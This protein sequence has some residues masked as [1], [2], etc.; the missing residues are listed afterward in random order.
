MMEVCHL[1]GS[2]NISYPK[3]K[4]KGRC[5]DCN[6]RT[7]AKYRAKHRQRAVDSARRSERKN[8]YGITDRQVEVMIG[9]QDGKCLVCN[10]P[11]TKFHID[12]CH[13]SGAVRGILCPGCNVGLGHFKER[14][15]AL[16]GAIR[17]LRRN[18]DD[19]D[20][21]RCPP[22]GFEGQ[23]PYGIPV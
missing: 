6:N 2:D 16:S 10:D 12:H 4:P 17:Y 21:T 15:E 8:V 5:L 1:C 9:L 3:S 11:L 18:H 19:N 23:Q 20:T 7:A 13:V 14:P 22:C